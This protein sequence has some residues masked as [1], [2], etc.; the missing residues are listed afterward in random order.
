[1]CTAARVLLQ[2]YVPHPPQAD[3]T[4]TTSVYAAPVAMLVYATLQRRRFPLLADLMYTVVLLGLTVIGSV[5]ESHPNRAS[6]HIRASA[7]APWPAYF[8][9]AAGSIALFWRHRAPVATLAV[10]LG[11]TLVYTAFG[12]ENGASL[13]NP[14]CALYT[15]CATARQPN[16]PGG[17]GSV[18]RATAAAGIT[19]A[20]LAAMTAARDPFGALNG[21]FYILPGEA[22][23]ALFA[24]LAVA[25]QRAYIDAIQQ[26]AEDAERS[27]EEEARSR[28]DAERLRIAR[29]LHDVV[30]HTMSTINLQA[31]VALHVS[32]DLPE[33]VATSLGTIR[34]ASKNGLRELRA[35]LAVLRQADEDAAEPTAPTPDLAGLPALLDTVRSSGLPV[36]VEISGER[37]RLSAA[38]ELAAY[39]IV[40]E[41][42]T[43]TLRH[44]GPARAMVRIGYGGEALDVQV[45]DDGAGPG[46]GE[47]DNDST[48]NHGS[49]HGLI[50]MRERALA[51]GGTLLAQRGPNGGFV[52]KARLP[53]GDR[54]PAD[55]DPS[56]DETGHASESA[57]ENNKEHA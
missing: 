39:R 5:A 27:R 2:Q 47:A 41:S 44:A 4:P 13:L 11:S 50:G 22:A 40:Q 43:N 14:M 33:P 52:V 25:N 32:R 17:I 6:D 19:F 21:S 29:E 31:G 55:D 24:G 23:A 48:H 3:V 53:L 18:R 15:V 42:L 26:R 56:R 49:G 16:A 46:A 54:L 9:V 45:T 7:V 35:I 38:V 12:Y 8:L 10:A 20:T 1:M 34:D 51:T 37:R 57:P 30:A 28:V 36:S